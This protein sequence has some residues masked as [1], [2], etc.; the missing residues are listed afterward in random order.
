MLLKVVLVLPCA[1]ACGCPA[2]L[3]VVGGELK[4][5]TYPP[6]PDQPV[7]GQMREVVVF[8]DADEVS[9]TD[10]DTGLPVEVAFL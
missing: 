4:L 9:G 10:S 3:V 7:V 1:C 5:Q 8:Q 2:D 6:V